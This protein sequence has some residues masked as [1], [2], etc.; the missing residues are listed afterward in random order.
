[1]LPQITP[2]P[3]IPNDIQPANLDAPHHIIQPAHL[4]P[5]PNTLHVIANDDKF[6]ANVFCFGAFAKKRDG[7]VY[8]DLTGLFPFMSLDGSIC[9]L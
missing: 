4:I 6:I 2:V 5:I 8:N 7:V 9:F 3:V 1:M